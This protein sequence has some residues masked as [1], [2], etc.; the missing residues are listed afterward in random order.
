MSF[1]NDNSV[2]QATA[3][4]INKLLET[5]NKSNY[6]EIRTQ[7]FENNKVSQIHQY[8]RLDND[9]QTDFHQFANFNNAVSGSHIIP[10]EHTGI[11]LYQTRTLHASNNTPQNWSN[12]FTKLSLQESGYE[13][14]MD[15][16][17]HQMNIQ[18][19]QMNGQDSELLSSAYSRFQHQQFAQPHQQRS[20]LPLQKD[21]VMPHSGSTSLNQ[22]HNNS[23]QFAELEDEFDSAFT[24]LENELNVENQKV[25]EEEDQMVGSSVSQS[26]TKT[27]TGNPGLNEEDKIKFAVLAKNVFNIMN[28]T[29]KGISSD[30]SDKFKQSS[31]MQLMNKISTREIEISNDKKKLVDQ[32]GVDIRSRLEDPLRDLKDN[33]ALE[34]PFEAALKVSE[35]TALRVDSNSW[36]GDFI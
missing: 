31:F 11:N 27:E 23:E 21:T 2:C 17:E 20:Y 15:S 9:L 25:E 33:V 13:Q 22:L 29:P 26:T 16:Q 10:Q 28:N 8:N 19:R 32:N 24:E 14:Q 4:P 5:S 6:G 35:N 1:F 18:G 34:S 36:Q 3:N 7:N 12:E 30:T